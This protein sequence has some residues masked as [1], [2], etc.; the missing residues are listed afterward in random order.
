MNNKQLTPT[1]IQELHNLVQRNAIQYY[2]VEIEIV[3]HYASAIEA[4]WENEPE[5]SFY[6]AQMRVYKE[7]WD[8]Q[9]LMKD[10]QILLTKQANREF[11]QEVKRMF[12]WPQVIE[13]VALTIVIYTILNYLEQVLVWEFWYQVLPYSLM[14]LPF[15]HC[16]LI[17]KFQK[18]L[19]HNFIRLITITG[20][21]SGF[22]FM[23]VQSSAFF[24]C[25][26]IPWA[27]AVGALIIAIYLLGVRAVHYTL[28]QEMQ[29][30]EQQFA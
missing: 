6:Q 5:V 25:L 7:F 15:F 1:Q 2:D 23:L 27:V 12:G 24:T 30:L 4:I 10:K 11:F 9:G 22:P 21:F 20:A 13:L 8:F 26:K 19:K 18:K 28:L 14:C 16:Y 3:D 17:T 29:Q